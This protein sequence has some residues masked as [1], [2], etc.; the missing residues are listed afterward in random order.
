MITEFKKTIVDATYTLEFC[1][2][3]SKKIEKTTKN[4]YDYL[5]FFF[6]GISSLK[7]QKR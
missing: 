6:D 7:Q 5:D 3:P 4:N 1:R 2:I